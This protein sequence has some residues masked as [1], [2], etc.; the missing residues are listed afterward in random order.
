MII[1]IVSHGC[2]MA[3]VSIMEAISSVRVNVAVMSRVGSGVVSGR[4]KA[5]AM[6]GLEGH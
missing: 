2:V 3:V 5:P 6:R 1:A 4:E